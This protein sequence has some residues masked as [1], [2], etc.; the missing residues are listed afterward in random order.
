MGVFA[1]LGSLL[2]FLRPYRLAAFFLI[3]LLLV[4]VAFTTAW[5][6][7]FKLFIDNALGEKDQKMLLVILAVLVAGV[8]LASAASIGRDYLFAYLSA[9]VLHDVRLK[10]FTQL[11]RLSL[12]FYARVGT[13]DIT[14]RFSNDL[15]SLETAVTWALANLVLNALCIVFGTALLFTLEWRLAL[16]TVVGLILC[17]VGPR[18]LARRSSEASYDVMTKHAQLADTVQENANV[19]SLIKAF[20]LERRAIDQFRQQST[21]LRKLSLRFSFMGYLVERV[22]NVTILIFEILVVGIGIWMVF[23]GNATLGTVVAFHAVFVNISVSVGGMAYVMPFVFQSVGGLQR[24][25]EVLD[26]KPKITDRPD[27]IDLPEFSNQLTFRDVTFRYDEQRTSLADVNLEIP[28]GAFVA[29][30]GSSG[31]GKSTVLNLILRFYDPTSGSILFDGQDIRQVRQESL[32]S[33]MGVVFQE[34]VLFNISVRENIRLGNPS[35]TDAEVEAAAKSAEIHDF[36]VS[37]PDGYDTNAGE[38]GA[39][40][41]GGQRQRLALARAL[42]RN[43][44]LLLLDEATSALDPATEAAVNETLQRVGKGRTVV[45]VTH[46]LSTVTHADRIVVMDDGRKKEEGSHAELL[47]RD[48]IYARLWQKQAGFRLSGTGDHAEVDAERLKGFPILSQLD[49]SIL[50][51]LTNQFVTERYPAERRVIV[52]GDPGNKFYIIVRGKVE[53]SVKPSGDLEVPK[54]VLQDGDYFGEIAL[55]KDVPR[56][57]TV[58]TILPSVFLTLERAQFSALLEQAPVLRESLIRRFAE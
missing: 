45:S 11:Q 2:R 22:P 36:L 43:P 31:S 25:E 44:P 42:T 57:A 37:L 3:L 16:V 35:A 54:A 23:L 27:A 9:N 18:G 33:Q 17:V 53:V 46:R 5:P 26:E 47:E 19:Q 55:L 52:E 4:D 30:V 28:Q 34:N 13:G 40:F 29:L 51:A 20:G 38:R 14:S 41:S 7:G 56:T 58:R 32:R 24:I 49:D 1:F 8:V 48:G 15:G 10:I 12:D 21:D 50:S 6:L 39:R